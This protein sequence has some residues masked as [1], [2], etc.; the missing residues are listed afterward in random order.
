MWTRRSF[1]TTASAALAVGCSSPRSGI[2][3]ATQLNWLHDPTFVAH[4]RLAASDPRFPVREGGPTV[5]PLQS[6]A[7]GLSKAAIC[8]IDIFLKHLAERLAARE[9]PSLR[10]I[11]CDFQRN[12][13]GWV[14]HPDAAAAL[15]LPL[16]AY[17][18]GDPSARALLFDRLREGRLRLGD[19]VGTET[20]S[21]L[22]AWTRRVGLEGRARVTPVGFD[23]SIVLG[24]PALLFP[25]YLNEEPFRLEEQIGQPLLI[26]DPVVDGIVLYGNIVVSDDGDA[27]VN[28][29]IRGLRAAWEWSRDNPRPAADLVAGYYKAVGGSALQRQIQKTV[30]FASGATFGEFDLS[31]NGRLAQ[32][33]DILK[34][35]G[36]LPSTLDLNMV[37]EF[38]RVGNA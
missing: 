18:S 10:A 35:G 26:V 15:G 11:F 34:L 3:W 36:T 32:T 2:Q 25:V 6:V 12:P 19:K 14:L 27:D 4:Y 8:G 22:R 30:E 5:F 9:R 28:D 16:T 29:Y 38:F 1:L 17:A 24:A 13:V 7:G 23:A 21:I 31:P 20:T 33:V 37:S